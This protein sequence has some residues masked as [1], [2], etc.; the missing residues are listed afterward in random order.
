MPRYRA[1]FHLNKAS[2]CPLSIILEDFLDLTHPRHIQALG[3]IRPRARLAI[4]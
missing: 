2:S 4:H 3:Q 1:L